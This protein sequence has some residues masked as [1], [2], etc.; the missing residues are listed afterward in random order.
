MLSEHVLEARKKMGE[1][2]E[3][4]GRRQREEEEGKKERRREGRGGEGG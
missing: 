2:E 4:E 3:M 1:K